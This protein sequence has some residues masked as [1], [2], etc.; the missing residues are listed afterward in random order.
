M[1]DTINGHPVVR[2]YYD[3]K[4]KKT[5]KRKCQNWNH[6]E[7][8]NPRTETY[9]VLEYNDKYNVYIDKRPEYWCHECC[10]EDAR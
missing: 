6:D 10:V 8:D 1:T 7:Y 4:F 5:W 9:L 2:E 3:S